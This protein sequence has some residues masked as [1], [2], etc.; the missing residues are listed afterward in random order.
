MRFEDNRLQMVMNSVTDK[1]SFHITVIITAEF[2]RKHVPR[3]FC[4]R[5]EA[6]IDSQK[7]FSEHAVPSVEAAIFE[8]KILQ[9]ANR[10]G[11]VLR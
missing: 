7:Q 9:Q 11:K 1:G 10:M 2:C 4:S 3:S 8:T 5:A 6:K